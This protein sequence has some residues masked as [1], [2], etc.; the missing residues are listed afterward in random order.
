[1][2]NGC[3]IHKEVLVLRNGHEVPNFWVWQVP[4]DDSKKSFDRVK[5][6]FC[7]IKFLSKS[8]LVPDLVVIPALVIIGHE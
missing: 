2:K 8:Y 4:G 1:M 6:K 3:L 7:F 5:L